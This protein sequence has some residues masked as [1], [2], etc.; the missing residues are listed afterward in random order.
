MVLVSRYG[1][2]WMFTKS[3]WKAEV[4]WWKTK[5]L[6]LL[7]TQKVV[8]EEVSIDKCLHKTATPSQPLVL[9]MLS[10]VSPDPVE[11]VQ[12]AIPAQTKDVMRCNILHL[13]RFLQQ[14]KLWQDS[15]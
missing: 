11:D 9:P 1:V 5:L 8:V 13:A 15:N 3:L 7:P 14:E 6:S 12:R 10:K 2:M 4:L